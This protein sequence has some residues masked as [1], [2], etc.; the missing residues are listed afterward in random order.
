MFLCNHYQNAYV[1]ADVD[2]AVDLL[3]SQ[4][5]VEDVLRMDAVQRMRTPD[6]EGDVTLKLAFAWIGALQYELIQP[7]SGPAGIYS[8][9]VVAD[10]PMRF[11]HVA[12]R[13]E[14]LDTVRSESERL[15]RPVV[16]VGSSGPVR[17]LYVDARDTLGHYLEYMSAP[18][19]FWTAMGMPG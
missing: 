10:Q 3:R 5:G 15:G 6:G 16:V 18:P 13:T 14:D 11:H 1:T 19:E 4:F 8:R 12:M 7:V 17:F 2:R 9:A